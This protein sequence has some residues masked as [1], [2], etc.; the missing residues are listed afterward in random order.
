MHKSK[1]FPIHRPHFAI[2]LLLLVSAWFATNYLDRKVSAKDYLLTIGGG[3]EPA[4]NQASLEANV[5]FFQRVVRE[6]YPGPVEH[7]IYFADGFDDQDDL[8]VMA[9]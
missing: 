4:G 1:S 7:Q 6:K 2:Q 3:Y 5:L 8:Q 9:T